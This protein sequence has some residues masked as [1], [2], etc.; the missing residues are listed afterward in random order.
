MENA[1]HNRVFELR[2][3]EYRN[4]PVIY[5]MSRDQRIGDNQALLYAQEMALSR[6]APLA[7]L[8][9]LSPSFL[10]ATIR[11]YDFMLRGLK[12]VEAGAGKLNIPFIIKTGDPVQSVLNVSSEL[13]AGLIV[14]DFSPLR[15][16]L[17][18][19]EQVAGKLAVPLHEMDAHNIVPCRI[20]SPK[21]EFAARTIRPKISRVLSGYLADIPAVKKHPY[22]LKQATNSPNISQLCSKLSI[23]CTV[24]PVPEF[25]PGETA[26]LEV[27]ERFIL[28]RLSRYDTDRNDPNL[29]GQSDLSPYLHFGQISS[30]R[31]ALEVSRRGIGQSAAAFLEE[32]IVRRELSDNFC[33]YNPFYDTFEG[34]PAWGRQTL[35]K[36]WNDGR[37]HI[38]SLEQFES[39]VTHDP[40]W[41][42]AQNEMVLAGKMHG[43]MRMYW[44]K[45]ILE[46]SATPEEAFHIAVYLNDRYS[47]DGRDPNGYSGISWSIGGTHDR[48]WG[49]RPVFGT[50]RYMSYEGC[51]RKFDVEEYVRQM[52]G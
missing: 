25:V 30:M 16:H 8:F 34:I 46:W 41:N 5:W 50:I 44:A 24:S 11:Q 26:A 19:K 28:N 45:K 49:E 21:L 20:A 7:I 36:H 2:P 37:T 29:D 13:E 12:E 47:L 17:E 4:G 15:I 51:R 18:W 38:Y 10:G 9:C 39:A 31:V 40:L 23:D 43:Y 22:P 35:Q 32:L 33:L 14:T 6:K 42:A 52:T 3:G 48:P 27:L 1:L